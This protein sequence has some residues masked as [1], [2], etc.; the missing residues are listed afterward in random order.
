LAGVDE[1]LDGVPA[2]HARRSGDDDVH[3]GLT[4]QLGGS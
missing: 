1:L 3:G 2:D 4:V